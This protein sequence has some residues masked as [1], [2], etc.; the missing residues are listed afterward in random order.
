MDL[1]QTFVAICEEGN[2]SR[3]AERVHRTPSAVSLQV[4]K[5]EALLGRSLFDRETRSVRLTG[6]GEVLLSY[7]R[8]LLA[9]NDEALTRFRQP[10][11]E[12]VVR[13]GAP[14]DSGVL[15]L[16]PILRRFAATHPHVRVDV[17]L[18]TGRELYRRQSE[19]ELDVIVFSMEAMK[20]STLKPV[21]VEDLVWVGLKGG[22]AIH[23]RPLPL[24]LADQ[25]C[26]WRSM[27]LTA[28]DAAGIP[29]RVAY[30]SEMCR[31]QAAAVE[32]DLAIAPL[33]ASAVESPLIRLGA[34]EGLP[35]L[36]RFNI[37][38]TI[39]DGA[40]EAAEALADH[41]T[42]RFHDLFDRGQRLF[43]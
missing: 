43:A 36:G 26:A 35:P 28:L 8:R 32:A 3:A 19:G 31:G 6:D 13:L 29:H 18:D 11:L 27:A 16:P 24:A 39:R 9:L 2:F 7:A 4:K 17:R 5:L 14:N 25:G 40:G 12:G 33:P 38:L 20:T 41:V 15:A 22:R 21:H 1:I 30:A 42:A 23:Q 10:D 34:A 37:Y